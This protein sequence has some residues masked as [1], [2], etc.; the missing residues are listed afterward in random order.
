M[1]LILIHSVKLS[2]VSISAV[3]IFLCCQHIIVKLLSCS[4]SAPSVSVTVS[5]AEVT[6]VVTKLLVSKVLVVDKILDAEGSG[7]FW[8]VLTEKPLQ[9]RVKVRDST[10][11]VA[12]PG[13]GS[14]FQKGAREVM[15]QLSEC[16]TG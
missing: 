7:H 1:K 8:D 10:C 16:H 12:D 3:L 6:E 14:H 13:G 4:L 2:S 15:I 11:G 5:P 9:C